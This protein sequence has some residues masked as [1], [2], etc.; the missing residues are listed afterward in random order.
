QSPMIRGP[1]LPPV[2][3]RFPFF[4]FCAGRCLLVLAGSRSSSSSSSPPRGALL[5]AGFDGDFPLA[6]GPAL[7]SSATHCAA[8]PGHLSFLSRTISAT[9]SCLPHSEQTITT[10][11][12]PPLLRGN[13]LP[14][15][16]RPAAART[17]PAADPRRGRPRAR[18]VS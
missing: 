17:S 14:L 15:V 4:S 9:F 3:S 1:D 7:A 11:V 10:V 16:I 6:A 2:V 12:M 5:A 8:P 13:A 18:P